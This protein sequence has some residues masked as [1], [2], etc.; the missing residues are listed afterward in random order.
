MSAALQRRDE[1]CASDLLMDR[2]LLGEL[3]GSDEGRRF[4]HHLREC[5]GCAARFQALRSLYGNAPAPRAEAPAPPLRAPVAVIPPEH[6]AV[7]QIVILRDGLLVGTEVFTAG[8]YTVGSDASCALRLDDVAPVHAALSLNGA[9]VGLEA[10]G[11]PLF[12]NGFRA[13]SC[14]LRPIDEVAVG[15]YVLR[16]RV[17]AERWHRPKLQLVEAERAPAAVEAPLPV[18]LKL[19]LYWGDTRVE[20]RVLDAP[21]D[22]TAFGITTVQA[23]DGGWALDGLRVAHGEQQR[24]HVGHLVCI[25]ECVPRE[26]AVPRKPVREW[27]WAVTGLASA[28]FAGVIALGIHGANVEEPDFV[29]KEIPKA[30]V[31]AILPAPRPPPLVAKRPPQPRPRNEEVGLQPIKRL[32]G[33]KGVPALTVTDTISSVLDSLGKLG[34]QPGGKRGPVVA[35]VGAAPLPSGL[36]FHSDALGTGIGA[37]GFKGLGS[38][39][40]G[41]VGKGRVIGML[42]P[43]SGRDVR[44]AKGTPVDRDAIAKVINSHLVEL[45]RCYEQAMMKSG[46]FG[47]R[48]QIE[49]TISP[50]GTVTQ[51]RVKDSDIKNAAVGSCVLGHLNGWRFPAGKAST[52]V[53]YPL[54]F[55]SVGY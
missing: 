38:M 42:A 16:A 41:N 7:L 44:A 45:S 2:W 20:V 48:M 12:V 26:A 19:Q 11:G 33:A 8:R 34:K 49:W 22:L 4:E 10:A 43:G 17:I 50:S 30:M 54:M 6:A 47:G 31:H 24:F 21:A 37:K 18:A 29:P 32:R 27:P 51:S 15:P 28:L 1:G 23:I 9:R 52:V 53:S 39:K 5:S 35:G 25:A 40:D 46:S 13:T 3:P 55:Q 14:E 36:D